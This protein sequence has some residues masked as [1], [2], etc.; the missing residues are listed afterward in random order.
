MKKPD[1]HNQMCDL[2]LEKKFFFPIKGRNNNM[3][4]CPDNM[5][6]TTFH[7]TWM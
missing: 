2:F 4:S 5:L 7:R 6:I 1:Y 3:R